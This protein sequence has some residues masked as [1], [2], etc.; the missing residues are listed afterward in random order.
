MWLDSGLF[1]PQLDAALRHPESLEM[2]TTTNRRKRRRK[3]RQMLMQK[4]GSEKATGMVCIKVWF[5]ASTQQ[6]V[7]QR[8][9][10]TFKCKIWNELSTEK[11]CKTMLSKFFY[12]CIVKTS[13]PDW[14]TQARRPQLVFQASSGHFKSPWMMR[15]ENW[16][17]R[18]NDTLRL[19]AGTARHTEAVI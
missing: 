15:A 18:L 7:E 17:L 1:K 19:G 4:V 14:K 2:F 10:Q 16:E 8:E 12:R 9:L 13:Q 5:N 11:K 3:W 6:N